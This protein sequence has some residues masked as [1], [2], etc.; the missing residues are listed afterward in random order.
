MQSKR[1]KE[2]KDPGD[3][4]DEETRLVRVMAERCST[5][6]FHPGNMM[7][8]R[9]GYLADIIEGNIKAGA[10]LTCHQTLPYNSDYD[11][12]PAACRGF[13]DA[14]RMRTVAGIMAEF[15]IGITEVPI[16]EGRHE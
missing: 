1:S 11:I 4:I 10:L 3:I 14:Y 12:D 7:H 9:P 15:S 16:P 5:C 8:L 6:V 13:W 2:S